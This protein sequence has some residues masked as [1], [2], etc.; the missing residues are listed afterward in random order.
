MEKRN[1]KSTGFPDTDREILQK[2]FNQ[3]FISKLDEERAKLKESKRRAAQE[4]GLQRR[5]MLMEQTLKEEQDALA[6]DHQVSIMI[7][8]IKRNVVKQSI[9]IDIN[10]ITARSLAKAMLMNNTITCLELSSHNLKDHAGSYIA[11]TLIR[12]TTLKKIEL[13]N[14]SLGLN[15]LLA[16]GESLKVNKSLVYLSL[17]SNPI[18]A[19]TTDNSKGITALCDALK[20]NKTLT[21]LNLW[22]TGLRPV[23]GEMLASALCHNSSLLFLD[24]GHNNVEMKHA[25]I[26]ADKLDANLAAYEASERIL[27][28]EALTD[29][30]REGKIQEIK[31][32]RTLKIEIL[33]QNVT[34][35][36]LFEHLLSFLFF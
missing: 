24:I 33:L 35:E 4:A 5:L 3:E 27:R 29:Q 12:N 17:D 8:L 36:P 22:R 21:S 34:N 15:S 30:E 19:S 32:V 16:F 25:R 10:S 6:A 26:I 13:D 23:D 11:R 31:N 20:S 14:N 28:E 9:R 1:L 2:A 18:F 7:D